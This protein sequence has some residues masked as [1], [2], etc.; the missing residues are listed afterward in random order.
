MRTLI[1]AI[2]LLLLPA[3][4]AAEAQ[5]DSPDFSA[6]ERAAITRV[7]DFLDDIGSMQAEFVQIGPDGSVATGDFYLRRP[8]RM[9]LEYDPP[10]PYLY[11]ADGSWLTFYDA[12]LEQRSDAPLGSTL[13]DFLVREDV[14]LSGDVTV[15]GLRSTGEIIEV[16]LVQTEDPR[17]GQLTMVFTQDPMRLDRWYIHDGQGHV[18]QVRLTSQR[19][20]LSLS[21][22]LFRAPRPGFGG[23]D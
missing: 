11:V 14:S 20:G 22:D 21:N 2:A 7:E 10:V 12:E 1:L 18:T 23:R 5:I 15:T 19:L 4:T 13:A 8:G 6:E 3:V 16:D 17:A 9:R